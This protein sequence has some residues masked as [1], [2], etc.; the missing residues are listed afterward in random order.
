MA[1]DFKSH[2]L[3]RDEKGFLGLPF[4]RLLLAGVV[5]GLIY[6]FSRFGIPDWAIP[7]GIA[8]GLFVLI[9][10]GTRGGLPLWQRLMYRLRGS[11]LLMASH[12]PNGLLHQVA[13]TMELPVELVVLD[14]SQVFASSSGDGQ[15]DMREWIAFSRATDA[16]SDDGLRFV[17]SPLGDKG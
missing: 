15:L 8:C 5:G 4:K 16:D 14:G 13:T 2:V 9:I 17:T 7:L 12:E 10:T 6:A 1:A 3:L 11:V